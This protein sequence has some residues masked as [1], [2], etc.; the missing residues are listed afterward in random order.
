MNKFARMLSAVGA[1]ALLSGCAAEWDAFSEATVKAYDD[2]VAALGDIED[3]LSSSYNKAKAAKPQGDAFNRYLHSGYLK[4]AEAERS[5]YDW[6]DSASFADKALASA[7]GQDVNPEPIYERDIPEDKQDELSQA[8]KKLT[9][10]IAAGGRTSA[11][12]DAAK[13]QT[14]FDCWIQEQEENHQSSDI[15]ACRRDFYAALGDVDSKLGG[16][17]VALS[18]DYLVY[19]GFNSTKLSDEASATLASA[20]EALTSGKAERLVLAG[21][22]DQAGPGTYNFDLSERRVDA[23]RAFLLSAGVKAEQ[24]SVSAFG[25]T[26]P[27]VAVS[28]NTPEPQNR[29]VEINLVK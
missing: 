24:I 14:S 20:A 1:A 12:E 9:T 5:E 8:R 25:D 11:P 17:L 23:V 29:R 7:E 22:A 18:N 6:V 27:R 19:F 4:L 26:Q 13:A 10:A 28:E 15:D 3:P 2:T 21:H 16:K